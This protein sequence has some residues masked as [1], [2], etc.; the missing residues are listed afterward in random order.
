MS[1]DGGKGVSDR[2][3]LAY[4]FYDGTRAMVALVCNFNE[5]RTVLLEPD[6]IRSVTVYA[7]TSE[8]S[9]GDVL[10]KMEAKGEDG[11]LC[12]LSSV[13]PLGDGLAPVV[14]FLS[15]GGLPFCSIALKDV[16]PTS[17]LLILIVGRTFEELYWW[18][19]PV[20]FLFVLGSGKPVSVLE[21]N[22]TI[23]ELVPC[24]SF[25]GC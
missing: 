15:E 21:V 25:G 14:C 3:R 6:C 7:L 20:V 13:R 17:F 8:K 10:L 19:V 18:I 24:G 16:I 12:K 2:C 23:V 5:T 11:F 9:L 22:D 4:D 1:H